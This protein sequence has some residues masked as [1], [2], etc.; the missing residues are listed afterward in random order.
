MSGHRGFALALTVMALVLITALVS[1]A[2]LLGAYELR[3]G[4]SSVGSEQAR[5]AAERGAFHPLTEWT[6]GSYNELAVGSLAAPDAGAVAGGASYSGSVRRLGEQYFLVESEGRSRDGEARSR[7]GLLIL[8][9]PVELDLGGALETNRQTSVTGSVELDGTDRAPAGWTCRE[10]AASLPEVRI[11]RA[12]MISGAPPSWEIAEGSRSGFDELFGELAGR[13]TVTLGEGSWRVGPVV[14][15]GACSTGTPTNWGD[16]YTPGGPC[17][18]H[19]P[20]IH[21]AGDVAVS[22]GW[23]QGV[24]LVDGYLTLTGGVE[25]FGVVLVRGGLAFEGSGGA[26]TGGAVV[27]GRGQEV[28]RLQGPASIR[29]SACA[30]ER[31]LFA[32]AA[33]EVLLERGWLNLY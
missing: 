7:E 4:R 6:R 24:L 12:D 26:V 27:L 3:L 22:G 21:M 32:S 9:R 14:E 30:V 31:A 8:L 23:G 1:A 17:G 10:P 20:V 5:G 33:P 28:N 25:F 29:F 13:A 2:L 18:S 15:G 11:D 19:F 16:P